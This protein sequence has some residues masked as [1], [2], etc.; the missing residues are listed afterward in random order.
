MAPISFS[1]M[2]LE[3][4]R[5]VAITLWPRLRASNA[6]AFPKPL[7]APVISQTGEEGIL[8]RLV[9]LDRYTGCMDI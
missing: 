3:E 1:S 7:V 5:A 4:L 6:T 9:E 8:Q 2:S